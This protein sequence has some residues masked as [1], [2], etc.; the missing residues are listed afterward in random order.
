MA[1]LLIFRMTMLATVVAA[2][3]CGPIWPAA[4]AESVPLIAY[5]LPLDGARIHLVDWTGRQASLITRPEVRPF[6]ASPDGSRILFASLSDHQW[7]LT[8]GRGTLLRKLTDPGVVTHWGDDNRSICAVPNPGPHGNGPTDRLTL[9]TPTGTWRQVVRLGDMLRPGDLLEILACSPLADQVVVA[10][11]PSC[12]GAREARLYRLSSG[13]MLAERTYADQA[14]TSLIASHDGRYLGESQR[15]DS[16]IWDLVHGHRVATLRG[17]QVDGFSWNGRR[18]LSTPSASSGPPVILEVAS[19]ATVWKGTAGTQFKQA[20]P[21][22]DDMLLDVAGR[23]GYDLVVVPA[24]GI[25][26]TLV[27]LLAGPAP[28]HTTVG[29]LT[30]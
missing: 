2:V 6:T 17:G 7:L 28:S 30:G 24:S 25:P 3:G 8:D 29:D 21:A 27:H 19:G 20:R 4:H 15:S 5:N 22:S 16:V 13:K 1:Q 26:R 12:C 9:L 18:I 10:S 14:V 23:G 11:T